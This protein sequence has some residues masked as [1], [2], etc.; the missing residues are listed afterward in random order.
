MLDPDEAKRFIDLIKLEPCFF[1]HRNKNINHTVWNCFMHS[2]QKAED[3]I[4]MNRCRVC[5][6][7]G[8]I[9]R[10]CTV[11]VTI[12]CD[13]CKVLGHWQPFCGAFISESIAK[14]KAKMQE[15]SHDAK[16][17]EEAFESYSQFQKRVA[18][19]AAKG[20]QYSKSNSI[21]ASHYALKAGASC[22]KIE[23]KPCSVPNSN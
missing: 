2:L 8:H 17:A 5:W 20:S 19:L 1:A 12:Q 13:H 15:P 11:K 23:R 4:S 18:E 14:L 3:L 21:M 6:Q 16:A 10:D 22:P 7:T 9:G